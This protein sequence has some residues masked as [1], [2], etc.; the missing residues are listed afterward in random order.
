M[1]FHSINYTKEQLD[2]ANTTHNVYQIVRLLL[3][4]YPL[5]NK[6]QHPILKNLLMAKERIVNHCF[7]LHQN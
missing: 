1:H 2:I 6:S 7:L 5:K 4:L 3:K